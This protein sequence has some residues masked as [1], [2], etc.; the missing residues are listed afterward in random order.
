MITYDFSTRGTQ[1]KYEFLYR[2]IRA[3]IRTGVIPGSSKLPSKRE[4]A[5]HLNVSVST[6]EQAYDLLVSEGYIQARPG[7][8]FYVTPGKDEGTYQ[9]TAQDEAQ[10][11]DDSIDFSSNRCSQMLFPADTWARL[12]R[13]TLSERDPELFET[14]PFNGLLR[15]R[16]AIAGYLYEFKGMKV[17]PECIIIGAG[18][19]YLYGRLLQLFGDRRCIGIG[20]Y[21]S[22]NLFNVS[23]GK[24]TLWDCFSVDKQGLRL[25]NLE[26]SPA[27]AIHVSPAN[28]FPT[29][30]VLS[31]ERREQLIEW[32]NER[33]ERYIIE[34]DYDSE[35][36]YFGRSKPPLFTQDTGEKVIYLNTFSKT[37]VPSL[38]ISYMVLPKTLMEIYRK[39]LSFFSCTVS[40]FEQLTLAEF[41]MGG[42]FERHI[43]RLR[44]YYSKQRAA[45]IDAIM[46]SPLT[47][48][49]TLIDME[50]GTHLLMHV[51]T[52]LSDQEIAQAAQDKGLRLSMLSDYCIE[53]TVRNTHYAVINIA[54]VESGKIDSMVGMLSEIF[55]EDIKRH[56]K[57]N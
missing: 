16:Q 22:V 41:I 52:N 38:R 25:D 46:A 9:D 4:L 7:S 15:L 44:R 18:T 37:L 55:A 3:D 27:E 53:Q 42:Y 40:S 35:L 17:R 39:Q 32:A 56:Q 51:N 5:H 14:V 50:V 28:H 6:I 31:D 13:K 12:M 30:A 34:D 54:S 23:Q 10:D 33:P 36:R 8:G 19:E 48:I 11:E 57:T 26:G 20:E 24:S 49:A 47:S 29:G 45:F 21:G 2:C 1:P 43:H